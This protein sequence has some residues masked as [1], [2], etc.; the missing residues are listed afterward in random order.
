MAKAYDRDSGGGGSSALRDIYL[1][2]GINLTRYSN[3]Q[4][5]KLQEILDAANT[6]IKSI[7]TKAKA[8]ETKE[9][10]RR[11]AA[12]IR[13]VSKDLGKQLN[14]QLELGFKGLADEESRFVENALR[15]VGVTANFELPAPSK[16]WAVASFDTYAGYGKDTYESYLDTFGDNVF[17]IWDSQVRAGYM[18]GMTAKQINRNVLGSVKDMEP[19]QMQALR[20]SLEMNTR[21]MVAHMAETARD[22]T[23]RQNSRLFSGYRYL[24][25]L[26]SRTCLVCGELDGKIFQSTDEPD[27]PQHPNCRC[28]WLPVIRGMEDDD[29][30]DERASADGPVSAKTTWKEWLASRSDEEQRDILGSAR[31]AAY[32][33]GLDMGSFVSDGR[34]LTLQQL[35]K[36]EGLELFGAGLK[37]RSW[38]E[39]RAYSDTYY[40]AIRNRANPTD[41]EK[42][43]KNT[44]FSRDEI[45]SIRNHVFINEHDL[46]GGERGRFTS[47]WQI[48]Q[49][50]QRMEQGWKGN[51]MAKYHDVDLLLLKHELEELKLMA[52]YEYN[53]WDAHGLATEKYPWSKTIK[54]LK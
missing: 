9:K 37:D 2:H 23:Y 20:K 53:A 13:R 39:Q 48:A 3:H 17:K 11:A 28:L 1:R 50:W 30:D 43:S 15:N 46:G 33:E 49:A 14:G 42:I 32:K 29:D 34:V 19:G 12:E 41:I 24:G 51:G 22:E 38:Q 35:M 5:R 18:L 7:I 47:D 25:T 26:D 8:I 27:L 6:Q 4:A 52:K 40:E 21:T 31:F 36:K 10:Y 45:Q 44:D 16:I 54:E